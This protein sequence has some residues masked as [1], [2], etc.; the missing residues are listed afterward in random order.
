M[1]D[2]LFMRKLSLLSPILGLIASLVTLA[3]TP[4]A[5]DLI[6][7]HAVRPYEAQRQK[8]IHD[9]DTTAGQGPFAPDWKSLGNYKIPPWYQD[10]KFGIFIHWGV[11]SV[12]AFGNE[13][14][15]RNM[16]IAGTP[17]FKHHVE[18]YGPQNKFGYKDFIPE[19]RAQKFDPQQWAALFRRAGAKYV[20]EVAEHH[21]GFPMYSSDLTDWC[22]AKMGPR[23]D[24]VRELQ[25]AVRQQGLHFG[26]SSHRAE[27]YF[28]LN[29]GRNFD[30]DVRDPRY[31]SFYGPAHAGVGPPDWVGH[32]DRAY[33]DDWLARSAEIVEKYH[34]DVMYFDWWIGQKEFAA[35][36]PRFVAFYYDLAAKSGYSPVLNYKEQALPEGAA[37]LDVERGQLDH[38]RPLHW[39][40]D[41]SI[42]DKSWGYVEHDTYK[43][44]QSLVWQ[45][46]DIVSKNG[47]LLLNIGP[48]SDG[49]IPEEEQD[50]LRSI[51]GWLAVNGEAIY[52]TRPW[53]TYGEG[54]TKIVGGAFHDTAAK[55]FTPQDIR[56]TS[57]G[58]VLYAI[59]L[60]WPRD[61][62]LTIH[63]LGRSGGLKV[64][65]VGLLGSK[66]EIGFSQEED[67]L[68][69]TVPAQAPGSY[70]Y[71]F[72][73]AGAR[74]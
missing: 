21:D 1:R 30:S 60:G 73:I 31:A 34:P 63:A 14:Y 3:Q 36:L 20:V 62:G 68:H 13:W 69:L 11:Y 56:F 2:V 4:D 24:L 44:A 64:R 40:T 9:V 38:I 17:E 45:L 33:L 46:V 58:T 35:Y 28:F 55:A 61:G 49:T 54:P 47:N 15:P 22:A 19:F 42:S 23:R 5:D 66:E 10:A 41:T 26:L 53:T 12:P 48:R 67:G 29:G 18:T 32:P 57:K 71:S 25:A 16:Y 39:Q 8:L 50:V 70:A 65:K 27:H 59:A 72:R 6:W 7:Q 43:S 74:P 37:V 52:G 51:G